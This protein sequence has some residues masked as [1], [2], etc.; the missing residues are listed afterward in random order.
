M[1]ERR[2]YVIIGNGIAGITAAETLR[3]ENP[4][5]EITLVAD[6]AEP[7]YYRPA[8]KDFLAGRV[9]QESLYM[10]PRTFYADNNVRF[11]LDRA[12]GI[13]TGSHIVQ[14][15][16]G[17]R[18]GYDRLL[19]AAGARSRRLCCPGAN[20]PNVVA[21]RTIIDYQNIL[22]ILKMPRRVVIC[23]SGPLALETAE[24]LHASGHS[25]T[26]L[27]RKP[28][29]WQQ[30]LDRTASELIVRQ[31]QREGIDVRVGEEIVEIVGDNRQLVGV[32]TNR[33]SRILCDLVIMAIGIEPV[34]GFIKESGIACGLGVRVDEY[35][36]TSVPDVYA[37]GDITEMINP[38][39]GAP[40]Y[41]GQWYSALQQ[42]RAAAYSMLGMLGAN[43]LLRANE[44]KAAASKR[45]YL[46]PIIKARIFGFDLAAV[47]L[48]NPPANNDP[49]CQQITADTRTH[50]Y[51]KALL[52]NG[53][54]V[55]MLSLDGDRDI[56][57]F[58]RAVDHAV[59]V[60]PVASRLF[61][62]DFKFN[63]W[64][65][66][67]KVPTPVL[68]V[69]KAREQ[70]EQMQQTQPRMLK[71]QFVGVSPSLPDPGEGSGQVIRMRSNGDP[72]TMPIV[73]LNTLTQAREETKPF[74]SHVTV[75]KEPVT[76]G[77]A[78]LVPMLSPEIIDVLQKHPAAA[79]YHL[80]LTQEPENLLPSL[81]RN[82]TGTP[83]SQSEVT[84][85][86]REPGVQVLVNH[87]SISRRHAQ[88][89]YHNGKYFLR[90]LDSKNGTY[91]NDI[92]LDPSET[93]IL[94]P[95]DQVRIGKII[96]Y[97]FQT[98]LV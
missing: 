68:A 59:N 14:L 5:A 78:Y 96:T 48:T 38:L 11:L 70:N 60:T 58:K 45:A 93:Y 71:S 32:I 85:I 2:S 61:Q 81:L 49:G 92:Q 94:K 75:S 36:H 74:P 29:L 41:A 77:E 6:N 26:H 8:L 50:I 66:A 1:L 4:L 69:S 95:G 63:N 73:A 52:K 21:L 33:G 51:S 40:I 34:T 23:G 83:L 31:E 42:G 80:S 9:G 65:D 88:I 22:N 82:W 19:L 72:Y 20:L 27:L 16:S 98:H 18:V 47:G 37:A 17:R 35:M 46:H 12:V 53:V 7:V 57:A 89:T 3:A 15:Q 91:V 30:V 86:G 44:S 84:Y 76:S 39:T 90:D 25:V 54:L 79:R 10:R 55:G 62:T 13:H 43:Q 28:R 24:V 56:V 87:N 97:R 64:L 67:Q